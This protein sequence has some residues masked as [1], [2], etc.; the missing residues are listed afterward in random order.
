MKI[1]VNKCY[2]GFELSEKATLR[3]AELKGIKLA[4]YYEYMYFHNDGEVYTK[5]FKERQK[6]ADNFSMAYY[7]IVDPKKTELDELEMANYLTN[8]GSYYK[9]F[10]EDSSRVDSELIQTIEELGEE[11]NSSYSNIKIVEIPDG[12]DFSINEY[13][14]METVYYGKSLK[15]I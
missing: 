9:S 6:D 1:A 5:Y 12:S 7:L 10:Y 11:A 15:T 4:I 14:G 3:M 8:E 2:G 13:D